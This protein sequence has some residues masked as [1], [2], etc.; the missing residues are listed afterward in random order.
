L[1]GPR[2][3]WRAGHAPKVAK[4]RAE[5]CSASPAYPFTA[6]RARHAPQRPHPP[7]PARAARAVGGVVC[8]DGRVHEHRLHPG[9]HLSGK[10]LSAL[11]AAIATAPTT[12][13][14]ARVVVAVAA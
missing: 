9:K 2:P 8:S 14:T 5:Q 3:T 1:N 12:P 4:P 6:T 10:H 11:L 13:P 7:I